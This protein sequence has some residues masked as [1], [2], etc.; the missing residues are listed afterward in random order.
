MLTVN[1]LAVLSVISGNQL[2]VLPAGQQGEN[3]TEGAFKK[4]NGNVTFTSLSVPDVPV[5]FAVP[6]CI[7][8]P[9]VMV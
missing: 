2:F 5:L 4:D 1:E 8:K 6:H 3:V 9:F 7:I